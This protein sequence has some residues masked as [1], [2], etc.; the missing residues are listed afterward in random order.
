MPFA[1]KNPLIAVVC[2]A[3]LVLNA[4]A[5][6]AG[7]DTENDKVSGVYSVDAGDE[8]NVGNYSLP[9]GK[10]CTN[11]GVTVTV[12]KQPDHGKLSVRTGDFTYERGAVTQCINKTVSG[13]QVFY[14]PDSGFHGEDH[15][16]FTILFQLVKLDKTV[17]VTVN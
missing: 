8:V 3:W 13:S 12:V 1:V 14:K 2:A 7:A 16:E 17:T 11:R 4:A 5:V 6:P 15:F 10:E 9:T